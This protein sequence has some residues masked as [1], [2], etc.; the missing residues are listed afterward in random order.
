MR[1]KFRHCRQRRAHQS[2][3]GVKTRKRWISASASPISQPAW[4]IPPGE[5]G[6]SPCAVTAQGVR[7]A[8]YRDKPR[9]QRPREAGVAVMWARKWSYRAAR[10]ETGHSSRQLEGG[11]L[12]DKPHLPTGTASPPLSP[13]LCRSWSHPATRQVPAGH[14]GQAGGQC[15]RKQPVLGTEAVWARGEGVWQRSLGGGG[16]P[17]HVR[18]LR[19]ATPVY[20]RCLQAW[21][22][23]KKE[24]RCSEVALDACE[25]AGPRC[26]WS[27]Q[28]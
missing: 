11:M 18:V 12:A 20:P 16:W 27:A 25:A 15:R 26:A 22:H 13:L 28:G 19:T 3:L 17:G 9:L 2:P 1:M 14:R 5:V 10:G 8:P 21:Q 23:L 4:R 24:L 6:L 7:F